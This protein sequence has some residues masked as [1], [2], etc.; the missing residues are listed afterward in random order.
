MASWDQAALMNQFQTIGLQAPTREW[1]MDT[2][3]SSHFTSDPGMLTSVSPPS[4]SSPVVVLGNGSS[5]PITSTGHARFP[6]SPSSRPLYLR[7][8]LLLPKS[9]TFC[10]FVSSLLIIVFL[11]NLTLLVFL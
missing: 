9:K 11:S 3:A 10:P 4:V 1:I 2:V 5:L 8:V 6:L 7:N